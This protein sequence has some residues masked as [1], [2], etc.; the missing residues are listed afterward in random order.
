MSKYVGEAL[1][2]KLSGGALDED[3]ETNTRSGGALPSSGGGEA[4][5]LPEAVATVIAK[6]GAT[7]DGNKDGHLCGSMLAQGGHAR[8]ACT[9]RHKYMCHERQDRGT[10][11]QHETVRAPACRVEAPVLRPLQL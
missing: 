5:A 8:V 7:E 10:R 6:T 2:D 9:G 11:H 3:S 1:K 4:E